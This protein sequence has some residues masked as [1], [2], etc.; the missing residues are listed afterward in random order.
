MRFVEEQDVVGAAF[1]PVVAGVCCDAD[2]APALV[3]DVRFFVPVIVVFVDGKRRWR[4][5]GGPVALIEVG[6]KTGRA[7][8]TRQIVVIE[9]LDNYATLA[10]KSLD[11]LVAGAHFGEVF[12]GVR[13]SVLADKVVFFGEEA[14]SAVVFKVEAEPVFVAVVGVC[15]LGIA[16]DTA[17]VGLDGLEEM[18]ADVAQ[19]RVERGEVKARE[20]QQVFFQPGLGGAE[21]SACFRE[22]VYVRRLSYGL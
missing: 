4:L 5:R 17:V 18:Q 10:V 6:Q 20:R 15:R 14:V 13:G 8:E 22:V 11:L 21:D 12:P 3:T 19:C 16:T 1:A 7:A 9:P 2:E